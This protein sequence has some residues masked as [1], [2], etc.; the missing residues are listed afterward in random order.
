MKHLLAWLTLAVLEATRLSG[1]YES[2]LLAPD[3][4]VERHIMNLVRGWNP[5]VRFAAGLANIICIAGA[6]W[7]LVENVAMRFRAELRTRR[8]Q[9]VLS[10]GNLARRRTSAGYAVSFDVAASALAAGEYELAH[11]GIASNQSLQDVGYYYVSIQ[12]H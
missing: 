3:K 9:E 2:T 12:R 4:T 10:L 1:Q 8:G 6:L 5:A 7:L 11:K